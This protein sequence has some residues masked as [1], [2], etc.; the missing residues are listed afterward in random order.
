MRID[1]P[2]Y[3]D[4]CGK[5]VYRVYKAM[6]KDVLFMWTGVVGLCRHCMFIL[7]STGMVGLCKEFIEILESL[8]TMS[9]LV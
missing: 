5:L 6:C 8:M 9:K 7:M 1:V 4:W 2:T 3:V